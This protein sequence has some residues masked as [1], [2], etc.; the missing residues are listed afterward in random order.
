MA[1]DP[2]RR[3]RAIALAAALVGLPHTARAEAPHIIDGGGHTTY[4]WFVAGAKG[5]TYALPGGIRLQLSPGARA[6]LSPWSQKLLLEPGRRTP[7]WTVS[8]RSGHVGVQLPEQHSPGAVLVNM[9]RHLGVIAL[10]GH[11]A[12]AVEGERSAI[13]NFGGR[14]LFGTGS[15]W[16]PL[17]PGV[18]RVKSSTGPAEERP[19]L[20][21]PG[22]A[23]V[24]SIWLS[25]DQA[26]DLDGLRWKPVRSAAGYQVSLLR[27]GTR[28]QHTTTR[29]AELQTAF[30]SVE[31][32][33][34]VLAVRAVDAAGLEG[35]A[36]LATL[37][38][39]GVALPAGAY[40]DPDGTIR[41]GHGQ[42]ASFTHADGLEMTYTGAREFL[43]ARRPIGLHK[44]KRTLVMLRAAGTDQ[45]ATVRLERREVRVETQ[46]G[47]KWALWPHDTI[48][49]SIR[50]RK[51]TA[52][53]AKVEMIPQVTLG[54]T[55][56][57][58]HW[59]RDGN[60]LT[61][62]VAPRS[63]RGPW[64]LRIDVKDQH[65]IPLAHDFLEIAASRPPLHVARR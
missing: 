53:A 28:I 32:G 24:H 40:T 65:G 63:G 2:G 5:A 34:Y 58:V 26:T 37:R 33:R 46:M 31:P 13:A 48:H 41:L 4:G 51:L 35:H 36:A 29:A 57:D 15:V 21:S 30:Q 11:V 10:A 44:G 6:R 43:D 8:L 52:S 59:H 38:V 16:K 42:K 45:T 14:A 50:L 12:A 60:V 49:I 55:P 23:L 22:L 25:P 20:P 7:T 47:P 3:L 1:F 19:L 64:V 39:V 62:D 56:I 18:A 9:P 27:N 54:T 61:T 17:A